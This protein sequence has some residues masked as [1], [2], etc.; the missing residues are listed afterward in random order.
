[1]HALLTELH[2]PW[3]STGLVIILVGTLE[4]IYAMAPPWSRRYKALRA[5]F[6]LLYPLFLLVFFT[7]RKARQDPE[8][9]KLYAWVIVVLGFGIL[10]CSLYW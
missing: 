4:V 7:G 9:H 2:R 1:M 5:L 10:F 8:L 6:W 3:L